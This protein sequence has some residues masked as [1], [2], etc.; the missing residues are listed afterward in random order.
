MNRDPLLTEIETVFPEVPM[1]VGLDLSFHKDDCG[2]CTYLRQDL[3][4]FRGKPI[5]GETIRV[6]HQEMTSLSAAGWRWALPHYLKY[7]LSNEGRYTQ[8]ET[9]FLIYNLGLELKFQREA[10]QRFGG[11]NTAQIQCLVHFLEW[12]S[13]DPHWSDYCAEDVERALNFMRTINA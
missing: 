8:T 1:P 6:L 2:H 4:E 13:D 7:C 10:L 11:L 3:E 5:T 9:E 12:C